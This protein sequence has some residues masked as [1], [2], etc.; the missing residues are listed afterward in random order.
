MGTSLTWKVGM[1]WM[2]PS[3]ATPWQARRVSGSMV[4][5]C[6]GVRTVH[7]S[8]ST[9]K[10]QR[11]GNL[12]ASASKKGAIMRHGPHQVAVKSTTTCQARASRQNTR[13]RVKAP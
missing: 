5:A 8:T 6:K 9:L 1:A 4:V 10:N 11:P 2:P 7:V 12:S 13:S 3:A